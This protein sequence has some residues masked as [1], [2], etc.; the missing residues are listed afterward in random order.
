MRRYGL[1]ILVVVIA[2]LTAMGARAQV[3]LPTVMNFDQAVAAGLV[4]S[5]ADEQRISDLPLCP[6]D[7]GSG[8][9]TS[10]AALRAAVAA[11]P[12][13]PSCMADP[14]ETTFSVGGQ[15]LPSV[16][17]SVLGPTSVRRTSSGC[18]DTQSCY[19]YGGAN[20]VFNNAAARQGVEVECE[21]VSAI[22]YDMQGNPA[23]VVCSAFAHYPAN[24]PNNSA[25]EVGWGQGT[26]GNQNT[27][28]PK[29]FTFVRKAGGVPVVGLWMYSL[30]VNHFYMYRVRDLYDGTTHALVSDIFWNGNWVEMTAV[31]N[32]FGFCADNSGHA[33]C[34]VYSNA[35][36]F[37][38]S[39]YDSNQNCPSLGGSG[40]EVFDSQ[41][42]VAVGNW[43]EWTPSLEPNTFAYTLDKHY[44]TCWQVNY[45]AYV[46]FHA[47]QCL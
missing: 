30:S 17:S 41:L 16:P 1:L 38:P 14:R 45:D 9:Y 44:F 6:A 15:A 20:S 19:M 47:T 24:D 13:A 10:A 31:A 29:I 37:S 3:T 36:I 12:D 21:V 27:S 28:I 5:L 7:S 46:F 25:N 22:T 34:G 23:H 42:R 8:G 4:P 39:C 32:Y 2:S 35:E 26:L 18:N 11:A 33:Y 43:Q 40:M